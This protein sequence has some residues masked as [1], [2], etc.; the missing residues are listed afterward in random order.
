MRH[1]KGLF[2]SIFFLFIFSNFLLAQDKWFHP[3]TTFAGESDVLLEICGDTII[4]GEVYENLWITQIDFNGSSSTLFAGYRRV[5]G[6]KVYYSGNADLASK[7]LLYDYNLEVGDSYVGT[8]GDTFKIIEVGRKFTFDRERKYLILQDETTNAED[9]WIEGVGS[10]QNG[11][12]YPGWPNNVADA[13][14]AFACYFDGLFNEWYG[15]E[16]NRC[17]LDDLELFCE[18]VISSDS[19]IEFSFFEIYPNPTSD[20]FII[21]NPE[22]ASLDISIFDVNGRLAYQKMQLSQHININ[23]QSWVK[24]IYTVHIS[25]SEFVYS[26][27]IS[28]H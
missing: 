3:I 6:S 20:Y 19:D 26:Q 18:N 22:N 9:K 14:S 2:H 12:L 24:G 27:F 17:E 15:L 16:P 21:N 5:E 1:F 28:I 4:D 8:V 25:S 13:G 10:V 7:I 23:C 11:Y